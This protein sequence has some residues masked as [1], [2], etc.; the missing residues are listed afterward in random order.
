[1]RQVFASD[2]IK[3]ITT[4]SSIKYLKFG[5]FEQW[6]AHIEENWAICKYEKPQHHFNGMAQTHYQLLN[7]LGMSKKEM[8]DFLEDTIN[9][10]NLLKTVLKKLMIL[11]FM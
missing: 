6:L 1:M 10:I 7:T 8:E 9:Y 2:R 5:T 3:L 4:P 11:G